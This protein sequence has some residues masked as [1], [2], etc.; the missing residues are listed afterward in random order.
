MK[1]W[2]LILALTGIAVQGAPIPRAILNRDK[3]ISAGDAAALAFSTRF[4]WSGREWEIKSSGSQRVGPGPNLFSDSS[5]NVWIDDQDRLHLKITRVRRHYL[6]AEVKTVEP[7]SYGTYRWLLESPVDNLDPNVVLG[8]FTWSDTSA[9]ANGEVDLEFSRWGDPS[10]P[11]AQYV[12]QPY[13][14]PGHLLEFYLPRGLAP[15]VHT[16]T[17]TAAVVDFES[18]RLDSQSP[19]LVNAWTFPGTDPGTEPS[20]PVATGTEHARMNLWLFQGRKPVSKK[21]QL[22]VVIGAFEWEP[23][24]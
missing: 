14:W 11:N 5:D 23:V 3:G 20:I 24:P 2:I 16:F 6:C 10:A 1:N 15:T 12:V 4:W 19:T 22:E 18:W 17:W 13:S 7:L 21:K 8:L 9:Y